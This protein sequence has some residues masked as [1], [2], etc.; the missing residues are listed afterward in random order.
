[1]SSVAQSRRKRGPAFQRAIQGG[2]VIGQNPVGQQFFS[3]L[4][5]VP[6]QLSDKHGTHQN[7][8]TSGK[9]VSPVKIVSSPL[10]SIHGICLE[11][12]YAEFSQGKYVATPEFFPT[13]VA[14]AKYLPSMLTKGVFSM[15]NTHSTVDG[16]LFRST[17]INC[18]DK[19]EESPKECFYC[20]Y[21]YTGYSFGYVCKALYKSTLASTPSGKQVTTFVT[22]DNRICSPECTLAHLLSI[23]FPSE[24]ERGL[25]VDWT[26]QMF[27][28]AFGMDKVIPADDYRL[29]EKNGGKESQSTWVAKRSKYQFMQGYQILTKS[30]AYRILA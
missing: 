3:A 16:E 5:K 11:E 27:K 25:C 9:S 21:E 6:A 14:P 1:M 20:R 24:R 26:M 4:S 12:I 28:L 23:R 18:D 17:P 29:L 13:L 30:Q 22:T 2:Q 8:P 15:H 7:V 10:V 19:T